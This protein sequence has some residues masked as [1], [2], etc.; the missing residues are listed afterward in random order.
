MG[1]ALK[2]VE[3]KDLSRGLDLKSSPIKSP[4]DSATLSLN[5]DY[6]IDGAAYTRFG[7]SQT[8]AGH[9][10]DQ[11]RNLLL[12]DF[13]KSD[14][15]QVNITQNGSKIYHDITNPVSQV[16][17]LNAS[18]IP[19][20]QGFNTNDDEYAVWG[21][22]IDTDLKFNGTT[23]TNLSIAQPANPTVADNGAGTLTGDFEYYIQFQRQISGV[24]VQVSDLNPDAQAITVVAKEIRITR[25]AS[26]DSQV[27]H[28]TIFRKSP[29]SNGVFYQIVD[30][31]GDPVT[32]V[33]ATTTYDDNIV[34]DGTIEADFD[35]Q[36]APLSGIFEEFNGRMYYV[37]ASRSTDVY[38]SK[39]D[40]P[41]NVPDT[42]LF[43]F[44]GPVQCVHSSYGAILYGTD[45][46][47]WVQTGTFESGPP[48]KISSELGILNN[49]CAVG[50]GEIYILG[51]NKKFYEISP[52]SF[53]NALIRVN[54]PLSIKVEP[55]ISQIGSSLSD[56]VNLSYYTNALVAKVMISCPIV[57]NTNNSFIIYNETQS[58]VKKDPC[59][60]Y[61]NNINA[62]SMAIFTIGGE[63]NLYAGDFNGFIWKI[64]DQTTHGDGAEVNG[65][66]TSGGAATLTDSTLAMVVDENF[67]KTLRI[68]DGTGK[69][70]VGTVTANT[71]TQF[72]VTPAWT[73]VPD[74]TSI[75]T[76]G[77]YDAYHFTNWKS[78]TGSYDTLK[79][80]WYILANLNASGNYNIDLI[81]QYDFNQDLSNSTI[82][83][84]N[85]QAANSI[86]G[87]F[88]WGGAPWGVQSVF[89]TRIRQYGRFRT[90]RFG[91]MNREAGQPFQ[92]N[93]YSISAQDKGLFYGSA[94]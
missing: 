39:P 32:I 62:S 3:Y 87:E 74:N 68:I 28:W 86:W 44:D 79:Q 64:D 91:F 43:I 37:D 14:G 13:K 15:T 17:G 4:E 22:G 34:T 48:V 10:M 51:T 69:D 59:W 76:C 55:L 70:Q 90:V 61:W 85:L 47:L 19:D 18:A 24:A 9:Q 31:S 25:P 6:S 78:V 53:S 57:V 2:T 73:T 5:V 72:T 11:L 46:S 45:K 7:T 63:R 16:T 84:I 92:I 75:Y 88:L 49:R 29:T 8:N 23:W 93:A 26:P 21:N 54:D 38:E 82:L 50:E 41:W 94:A 40:L 33:V 1:L 27:T 80:L 56:Y 81:I 20:I 67:G 12:Y 66:A 60:Q 83:N 89:Q 58:I 52:T 65:T 30:G 42:N 35:N 36:A 77:G 71:A